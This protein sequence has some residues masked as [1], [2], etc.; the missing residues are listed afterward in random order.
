MGQSGLDEAAEVLWVA[1]LVS[2]LSAAR[3]CLA[4]VLGAAH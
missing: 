4:I 1:A 2:G 3:V